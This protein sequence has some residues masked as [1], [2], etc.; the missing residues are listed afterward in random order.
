MAKLPRTEKLQETWQILLGEEYAIKSR[1]IVNPMICAS[2]ITQVFIQNGVIIKT[3]MYPKPLPFRNKE[4]VWLEKK[5]NMLAIHENRPKPVV[6]NRSSWNSSSKSSY[7]QENVKSEEVIEPAKLEESIESINNTQKRASEVGG[8]QD[9][10][11]KK[12]KLE[13][14]PEVEYYHTS[15]LTF[16]DSEESPEV[17]ENLIYSPKIVKSDQYTRIIEISEESEAIN[18]SIEPSDIIDP[19][20]PIYK[21]TYC[22]KKQVSMTRMLKIPENAEIWKE[23]LGEQYTR[24]LQNP[25]FAP[26]LICK[27]HFRRDVCGR[28]A[29]GEIPCPY[30]RSRVHQPV[31]RDNEIVRES[32]EPGMLEPIRSPKTTCDLCG[33]CRNIGEM[34][35]TPKSKGIL[36]ELANFAPSSKFLRKAQKN[37]EMSLFICAEH[38]ENFEETKIVGNENFEEIE[39][40]III[41]KK[42]EIQVKKEVV[43]DVKQ[44]IFEVQEENP[45]ILEDGEVQK[46]EFCE[47]EKVKRKRARNIHRICVYCNIHCL[48]S[49]MTIVPFSPLILEKWGPV[50]GEEFVEKVQCSSKPF[51]C[52]AHFDNFY[53]ENKNTRRR[54]L[55][56][57]PV[58]NGINQK[59]AEDYEEFLN[60]KK[61]ERKRNRICS[62][63]GL[64][65]P[66]NQM[67]HVPRSEEG[68][69]EWEW[70][71]GAQFKTTSIICLTHFDKFKPNG[72]RQRNSLPIP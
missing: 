18:I 69:R 53:D 32:W 2:H 8:N 37:A 12:V 56:F 67:T 30:M 48:P 54:I 7:T 36:L 68:I 38:L 62:Y 23:H 34:R 1:N 13:P 57:I 5:E 26:F 40:K 21:C 59:A 24:N 72:Q 11:I 28:I 27:L 66:Q 9:C 50:F 16:Q 70:I 20:E 64:K 47:K 52:L 41:E 42:P 51:I 46:D 45:E 43:V 63:C 17:I 3:G 10:P 14:S 15:S 60:N 35:Q 31:Y 25:D 71:L 61:L 39:E 33:K 4:V 6:T 49:E 29:Y 19:D 65:L 58:A 44:E 22:C 55:D